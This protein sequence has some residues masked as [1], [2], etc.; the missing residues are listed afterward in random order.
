[1]KSFATPAKAQVPSCWSVCKV[2]IYAVHSASS[3]HFLQVFRFYFRCTKCAAEYTLKT[4]PQ[5]SDYIVEQGASR[6]YEPWREADA[7]K[8]EA[9]RQREEEERGNAMKALENRTL[10]SK[11]EMDLM[12]I[13][14]EMKSLRARHAGVTTEQALAAITAASTS[15]VAD[16]GEVPE[17]DLAAMRQFLQQKHTIMRRLDDDDDESG[18]GRENGQAQTVAQDGSTRRE[19]ESAASKPSTQL[20]KPKTAA[21][22]VMVK[23]KRQ[24]PTAAAPAVSRHADS[25]PLKRSKSEAPEAAVVRA[26]G[27]TDNGTANGTSDQQ[28]QGGLLGL[29]GY[30]SGSGDSDG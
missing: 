4:D 19:A 15:D 5:N 12:E 25:P 28:Q 10:D 11:R 16:D 29:G 22:Q 8:A 20:T 18:G 26:E 23:P 3:V 13:L 27:S 17:E 2:C 7:V 24:V 1:M 14:D 21:F 30:G 6:N 9:V